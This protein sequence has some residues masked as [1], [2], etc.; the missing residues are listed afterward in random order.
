MAK[1]FQVDTGGTLTT[2]LVAYWKL[3]DV[4]DFYASYNL[5]NT[6]STP[7]NAAKVNNGADFGTSNST[8]WLRVANNLGITGGNISIALWVK[9][10]TEIGSGI[11]TFLE[12]N[13]N[14]NQNSYAIQYE[15]N[16]GTRRIQFQRKN[17]GS[18]GTVTDSYNFTMGTTTWYHLVLTYDGTNL[19]GYKDGTLITGPTAASGTGSG[20]RTD[21]V[22]IATEN[23]DLQISS[24]IQDETGIWSK[25]LSTTEITDLYNGGA[26]QTMDDIL[27]VSVNDSVTVA[28]SL[29][30]M[31]DLNP[32]VNDAVTVA[33][34]IATGGVDLGDISVFDAVTVTESVVME[35][36]FDISVFESVAVS[37]SVSVENTQLGGISVNDAVTVSE[38]LTVT[39]SAAKRG[40]VTMR[41]NQQSYP[42]PMDDSRQL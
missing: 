41:S 11:Y 10:N 35:F 18:A 9:L 42:I 34:N 16:G 8:K 24:S 40:F 1:V 23:N 29:T 37:E 32:N 27:T 4:N 36:A 5:T 38:S 13:S 28:E 39:V 17:S 14:T 25:A 31:E 33:E 2:N 21:N 19:R 3:E 6:G 12:Q 15:Y 20:G 30:L 7:F 22:S 26:G